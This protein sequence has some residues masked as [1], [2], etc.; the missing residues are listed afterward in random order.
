ME[1]PQPSARTAAR[2]TAP[3][4]EMHRRAFIIMGSRH[5]LNGLVMKK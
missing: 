3:G 5:L 4:N 1:L 2:T